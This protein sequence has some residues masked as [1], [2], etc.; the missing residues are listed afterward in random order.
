M[1]LEKWYKKQ[2]EANTEDPPEKVWEEVQNTLDIDQV[3][4]KVSHELQPAARKNQRTWLAIA[5]SFLLLIAALGTLW[6]QVGMLREPRT[7]DVSMAMEST[8]VQKLPAIT[9]TQTALNIRNLPLLSITHRNIQS[10]LLE[11]ET[12]TTSLPDSRLTN[13]SQLPVM[14]PKPGRLAVSSLSDQTAAPPSAPMHLAMNMDDEFFAD[15]FLIPIADEGKTFTQGKYF[16]LSMQY[17]NTW[18]RNEKTAAGLQNTSLVDT[19]PS[20]GKSFGVIFGQQLSKSLDL[21][22]GLDIISEKSQAYNEYV[23]GQYVSTS[24]NMDYSKLALT[25]AYRFTPNSPHRAVAGVYAAYLIDAS[26]YTD[27]AGESVTREYSKT[28]FGLVAGYQY[29]HQLG[30]HIQLGTGVYANYGLQNVF[31]GNEQLP[32]TLNRTNLL[33]LHFGL[34]LGYAF[35]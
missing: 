23:H 1:E 9:G 13:T 33:S 34:S 15:D 28:D 17:A 26:Q 18:L 19:R 11:N 25:A 16:G 4:S 29:I 32:A 22:L 10:L 31:A 12:S 27:E 7:A 20:F 21:K 3:W 8:A 5:A 30:R 14:L 35:R 24:I 2:I 6:Y